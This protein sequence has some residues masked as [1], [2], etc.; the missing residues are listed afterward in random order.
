MSRQPEQPDGKARG[1]AA[2]HTIPPDRAVPRGQRARPSLAPGTRNG[3]DAGGGAETA[4]RAGLQDESPRRPHTARHGR[5]SRR[6]RDVA[7]AER[8]GPGGGAFSIVSQLF[9]CRSEKAGRANGPRE[10][11]GTERVEKM[12][13]AGLSG[14]VGLGGGRPAERCHVSRRRGRGRTEGKGPTMTEE[15]ATGGVGRGCGGGM[16]VLAWRVCPAPAGL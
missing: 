10:D 16:D 12:G 2:Q 13:S 3:P 11:G 15:G 6:R 1:N 14:W 4:P 9:P 8:G 7:A 5:P